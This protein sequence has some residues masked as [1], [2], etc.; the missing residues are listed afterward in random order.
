MEEIEEKF[1]KQKESYFKKEPE[2]DGLKRTSMVQEDMD[3]YIYHANQGNDFEANIYDEFW[4]I[5]SN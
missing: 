3:A 2:D 4:L 1:L 5:I